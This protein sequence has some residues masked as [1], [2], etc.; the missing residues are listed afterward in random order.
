MTKVPVCIQGLCAVSSSTTVQTYFT[1]QLQFCAEVR[2]LRMLV[3][4]T[5]SVAR[6]TY[7]CPWQLHKHTS[8]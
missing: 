4:Y 1:V 7:H 3:S 2:Y 5:K 8:F 6:Y